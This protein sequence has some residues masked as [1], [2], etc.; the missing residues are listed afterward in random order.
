M[1]RR[2][3]KVYTSDVM[4][5]VKIY[6]LDRVHVDRNSLESVKYILAYS[7]FYESLTPVRERKKKK[8]IE[9]KRERPRF[10]LECRTFSITETLPMPESYLEDGTSEMRLSGT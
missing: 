2:L 10:F 4:N 8:E 6:L 7:E 9:T 1:S 5:G 3:F